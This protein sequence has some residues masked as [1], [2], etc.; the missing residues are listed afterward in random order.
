MTGLRTLTTLACLAVL[1]GV[2][3]ACQTVQQV[4]VYSTTQS[5]PDGATC[6]RFLTQSAGQGVSCHWTY[7]FRDTAA[8]DAAAGLW[9]QITTCR[10]GQ[11]EGPDLRVNHPDSYDL[12]SWITPDGIYRLSVKDKTALGATL[13][14]LRFE[15]G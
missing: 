1:P 11:A 13:V 3:E 5:A 8:I 4:E 2:A 7:G 15:D 9:S 14:F 12:R 10:D 6:S